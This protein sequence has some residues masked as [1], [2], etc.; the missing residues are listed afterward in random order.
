MIVSNM[1]QVQ[2]GKKKKKGEGKKKKKRKK[3]EEKGRK[4]EREKGGEGERRK[5]V[6]VL[7]SS[8]RLLMQLDVS[9]SEPTHSARSLTRIRP[10]SRSP[11]REFELA[12]LGAT[13]VSDRGN[14]PP[15]RRDTSPSVIEEGEFVGRAIE[16]ALQVV[17]RDRR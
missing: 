16:I 9:M 5:K 7:L 17:G 12:H 8:V 2:N 6:E 1:G 15:A 14:R 13:P 10:T 11:C 3:G 4:E